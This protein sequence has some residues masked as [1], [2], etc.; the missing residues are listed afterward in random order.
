MN[1]VIVLDV[2]YAVG[3]I[4]LFALIGLLAKAVEKL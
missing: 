1:G 2:V 4:A 3:V